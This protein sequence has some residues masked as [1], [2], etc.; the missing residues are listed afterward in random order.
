[1]SINIETVRCSSNREGIFSII[2]PTWNNLAFL[3][4]CIASIRK[5]ST[6]AHQIIVHVNEGKDGT[7]E[8]L[9]SQPDVD[10]THS[11]ENVG[12]CYALNYCRQ[13][14]ATSGWLFSHS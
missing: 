6:F 8:W 7:L 14:M 2:I 11:R 9:K 4:C 1:M 3:Q 10:Y 5:N 12:I 13:L